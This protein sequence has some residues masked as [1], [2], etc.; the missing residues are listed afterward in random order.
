MVVPDGCSWK[1]FSTAVSGGF[2]WTLLMEVVIDDCSWRM[3]VHG[4]CSWI[5]FNRTV[6][7]LFLH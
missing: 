5:P 1:L 7:S 2:F 6:M 3:V 4:G